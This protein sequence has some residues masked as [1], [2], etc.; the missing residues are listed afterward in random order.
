MHKYL[1]EVAKNIR[2]EVLVV[3]REILALLK[4]NKEYLSQPSNEFTTQ[5]YEIIP[6]FLDK[7]E[8][9]RLIDVTNRTY[10]IKVT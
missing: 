5:G 2:Y 6:N 4:D 1:K 7:D 10:A 8:C 3:K 9:D